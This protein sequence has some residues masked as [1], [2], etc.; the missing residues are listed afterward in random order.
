VAAGRAYLRLHL[1]AT[2]LGLQMHP[3]SQAPQEFAEMKPYYDQMHQ[4]LLGRPATQEV[5]QMLC[6]V[7]YCADQPHTPRRELASFM[8]A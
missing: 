1:K 3:L 4:L 8:R 6:R 2:E 7:G 5:V